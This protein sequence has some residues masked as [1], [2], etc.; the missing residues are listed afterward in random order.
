MIPNATTIHRTGHLG[1]TEVALTLD[2]ESVEHLMSVLTDLYSDTKLAVVREA[3]QNAKD[4]HDLAGIERPIEIRT[5]SFAYPYLSVQDFGVGLSPQE[6]IDVCSKYGASTKRGTNN[7]VGMLGFGFKAPLA[8]APQFTVVAVKHGMKS[9]VNIGRNSDG[10]GFLNIV[11]VS[12][13]DEGNGVLIKVPSEDSFDST[14]HDLFQYWPA[15]SVLVDGVEPWKFDGTKVTDTIFLAPNHSQDIIVMG[16]IPYTVEL[17]HSVVADGYYLSAA[18]VAY[19][20]VGDVSF[21]PNRERLRYDEKTVAAID[22][23]RKDFMDAI[24]D[25]IQKAI[26]SATNESEAFAA[27]AQVHNEW[28]NIPNLQVDP[29]WNGQDIPFRKRI[30]FRNIFYNSDA[31]R[32]QVTDNRYLDTGLFESNNVVF[33][34]NHD[35]VSV[36]TNYKRKIS[37]YAV[38][39]NI[40]A[41]RFIVTAEEIPAWFAHVP[42]IDWADIKSV[43]LVSASGKR[44]KPSIKVYN[45]YDFYEEEV[46]D[47]DEIIYLSPSERGWIAMLGYVRR[48]LPNCTIVSVPK[49]R[50]ASF[51]RE[52]PSMHVSEK[53]TAAY[54]EFVAGLTDDDKRAIVMDSWKSGDLCK[55]NPALIDDQELVEVINIAKLRQGS[56]DMLATIETFRQLNKWYAPDKK[57]HM[58][59]ILN[60]RYSMLRIGHKHQYQYINAIYKENHAV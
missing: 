54:D 4:S 20:N 26:G 13:T 29:V 40:A 58:K 21:T 43:K 44:K 46:P 35:G 53:V 15:G 52:Y 22:G 16:G 14:C 55:L 25:S 19:V 32:F 56:R 7:Q 34:I 18:V 3:A 48:L 50:W 27:Y 2:A 23:I 59:D 37:K 24:N 8:Y 45:G 5:P 60:E 17:G 11:D 30:K 1:G 39:N 41:S 9:T 57:Y 49:N 33:I 51:E 12:E 42:V 6:L 47:D 31:Y 10:S 36:S 38:D 28:S